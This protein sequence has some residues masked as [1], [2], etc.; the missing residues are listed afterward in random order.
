MVE[1]QEQG[2][3]KAVGVSNFSK[4]QLEELKEKTGKVP[5]VNQVELHPFL[6]Q[7]DLVQYCQNEGIVLM[8][9][10][11]LYN[12]LHCPP[13]MEYLSSLR[14]DLCVLVNC[15]IMA[16]QHCFFILFFM[17]SLIDTVH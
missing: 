12:P 17:N 2:K 1:C 7:D 6:T 4:R 8:A 5:A 16:Y 15:K 9:Y 10:P 14:K 13:L 3:V 11:F